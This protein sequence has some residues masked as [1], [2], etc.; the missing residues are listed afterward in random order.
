VGAVK[1]K[2]IRRDAR[3]GSEDAVRQADDR[4]EIKILEQLFLDPRANPVAEQCAIGYDNGGAAGF[5]L[6]RKFAHDE[7]KKKQ[8]GF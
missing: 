6:T 3:I 1:E 8:R 5:R 4:V 7:L 2:E